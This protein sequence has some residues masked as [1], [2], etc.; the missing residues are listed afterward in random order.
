M[1][2]RILNAHGILS[3]DVP[4]GNLLWVDAVNGVD[5]LAMRG[6]MTIP[7]KTLVAA[8]NAALSGDTI[9]VLLGTYT[10]DQQLAKNGVNWHF[11]NGAVVNNSVSPYPSLFLV[12]AAM[13]FKVTGA[14]Y[15]FAASQHVLEVTD[16]SAVVHFQGRDLYAAASAISMTS[17]SSVFVEADWI[18]GDEA[19]AIYISGGTLNVRARQISSEQLHG[20]QIAGGTVDVDAFQ[21]RSNAAKGIYFT[22]G[23]ARIRAFEVLAIAGAA[24]EYNNNYAAVLSISNA[25]LVSTYASANGRAVYIA[26]GSNALKL[27]HCTLIAN[28]SGSIADS[29]GGASSQNVNLYGECAANNPTANVTIVTN[30]PGGSPLNQNTNLT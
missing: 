9:M 11:I 15:F 20:M 26:S 5:A 25:R 21:I 1:S 4:T 28:R 6:R 23:T 17:G 16:S 13:T 8:K 19:S 18:T 22:A 3:S 2:A 27:K 30:N 24:V 10:T 29:I 7:F 14:G 12:N